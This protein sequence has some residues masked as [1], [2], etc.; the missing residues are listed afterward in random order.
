MTSTINNRVPSIDEDA[1]LVGGIRR[2]EAAGVPI[3]DDR[4]PLQQSSG[5]APVAL[6][7]AI[8]SFA[9]AVGMVERLARTGDADLV[10]QLATFAYGRARRMTQR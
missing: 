5:S 4:N 2:A 7:D 1:P 10:N 3:W 6:A 8:A 9:E